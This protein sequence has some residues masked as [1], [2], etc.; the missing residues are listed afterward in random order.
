MI[1]KVIFYKFHN[2]ETMQQAKLNISDMIRY[3]PRDVTNHINTNIKAHCFDEGKEFVIEVVRGKIVNPQVIPAINEYI[4]QNDARSF[5]FEG[6][7]AVKQ[8]KYY[9]R[10]GS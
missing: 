3:L 2:G 5:F 9:L 4:K 8:G 1:A 6:L 10:W 7:V